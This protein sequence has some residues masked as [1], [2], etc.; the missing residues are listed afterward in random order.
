MITYTSPQIVYRN[1]LTNSEPLRAQRIEFA[2][3]LGTLIKRGAPLIY[4]DQSS[5]A[6][7]DMRPRKVW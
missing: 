4:M 7:W 2:R 5:F 6:S 1:F 3:K